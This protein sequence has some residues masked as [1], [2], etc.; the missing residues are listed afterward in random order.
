MIRCEV[1]RSFTLGKYKE[2]INVA[3][4]GTRKEN[5]F[6]KGDT[7]ECTEEMA[8]YLT[9]NNPNEDVVVKVLEVIPDKV[10]ELKIDP[11]VKTTKTFDNILKNKSTKKNKKIVQFALFCF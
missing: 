9:G 11:I 3:K 8:K 7:F 2:L 6:D 1:T 5:E 10:E 4:V